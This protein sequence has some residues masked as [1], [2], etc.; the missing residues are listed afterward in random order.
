MFFLSSN[1]WSLTLLKDV[2]H[3]DLFLNDYIDPIEQSRPI[4]L[5]TG[6]FA[7]DNKCHLRTSYSSAERMVYTQVI[8]TKAGGARCTYAGRLIKYRQDPNNPR[9]FRDVSKTFAPLRILDNSSYTQGRTLF[10]F[11]RNRC[12]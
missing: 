9:V 7:G 8:D 1:L 3:E 2:D 11:Y 5:R 12:E 6:M 4:V 10:T